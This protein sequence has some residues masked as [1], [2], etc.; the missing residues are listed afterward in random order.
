MTIKNGGFKEIKRTEPYSNKWVH[1]EHVDVIRPDGKAGVFG[2]VSMAPGMIVAA[3]D[4]TSEQNLLFVKEFRYAL[5]VST[6]SLIGGT[7]AVDKNWVV[8]E[9]IEHAARRELAEE[10]GFKAASVEILAR[11]DPHT[12]IIKA[13]TYVVLARGLTRIPTNERPTSEDVIELIQRIPL[14]KAIDMVMTGKITHGPT[15]AA[16]FMTKYKLQAPSVQ[17]NR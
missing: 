13:D 6:W 10:V 16:L 11:L 15:V 12:G 9:S 3:V 4:N 1:V 5:G 2:I 14:E 8:T 17:L 7:V